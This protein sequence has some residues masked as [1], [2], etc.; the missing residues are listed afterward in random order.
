M[1]VVDDTNGPVQLMQVDLGPWAPDGTS[2][3]IRDKTPRLGE[4]GHASNPPAGSHVIVLTTG[5]D[6]TNGIVIATNHQAS[7][8]ANLQPGEAALY[9][10]VAVTRILLGAE[11]I[12]VEAA[13]QDITVN[14]AGT[15]TVNAATKVR[16]VT[17]RLEVTGD[18]VDNC[19]AN[20]VTVKAHRDDYNAHK[21]SGVSAGSA[22][23]GTTDHP[24]T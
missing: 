14:G 13:G 10:G 24:A 16:L 5:G 9:N 15:L 12:T 22:N 20:S 6:R 1:K 18:I 8:L 3:G 7:R 4:Y 11:A 2:L 17:P 23:T 21:H 19:D